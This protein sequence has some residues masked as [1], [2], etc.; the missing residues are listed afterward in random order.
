MANGHRCR[1]NRSQ[2]M[3]AGELYPGLAEQGR[4]LMRP[5][6]LRVIP[7]A[8]RLTVWAKH[9]VVVGLCGNDLLP[10]LRQQQLPFG[11]C[12]TQISDLTKPIRPANRHYVEV[13]RLTVTFGPH[14]T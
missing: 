2:H 12:Q 8:T 7:P 5:P 11:Q 13:L 6:T 3:P 9:R 14:Q 4:D 1:H 10:N